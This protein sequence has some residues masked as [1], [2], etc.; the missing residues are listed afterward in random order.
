MPAVIGRSTE[1]NEIIKIGDIERRAGLYVLGKPRMG[2]STLLINVLIQ[3]IANGHG[4]FFL[5]P[6]GEAIQKVLERIGLCGREVPTIL[7]DPT[8][9][10]YSIGINPLHCDD[11]AN[12]Q[13]RLEAYTKTY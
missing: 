8:D 4:V 1:T 12:R 6:H 2:K 10:D 9:D 5:D 3:N 11:V 13:Q 7:Y